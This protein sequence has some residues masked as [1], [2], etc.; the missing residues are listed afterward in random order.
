MTLAAWQP[1]RMV[2]EGSP[3]IQRIVALRTSLGVTPLAQPSCQPAV[4]RPMSR[5][6]SS[7]HL[8]VATSVCARPWL[9]LSVILLRVTLVRP[10]TTA[11]KS[12]YVSASPLAAAASWSTFLSCVVL[13][14]LGL[15]I[16]CLHAWGTTF[17]SAF[18]DGMVTLRL[19]KTSILFLV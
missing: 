7:R 11:V 9:S 18:M 17:S 2:A 3:H 5:G 13:A 4:P 10:S 14:V 15:A 1:L 6:A 19:G 16:S 8:P 12:G